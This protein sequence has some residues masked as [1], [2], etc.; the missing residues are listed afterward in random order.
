MPIGEAV[1]VNGNLAAFDQTTVGMKVPG[2]LQTISVGLA[3]QI[4]LGSGSDRWR[5][6]AICASTALLV[7][8]SGSLELEARSVHPAAFL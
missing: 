8:G 5:F 7:R 3:A 1:T 2:R 4:P 6:G